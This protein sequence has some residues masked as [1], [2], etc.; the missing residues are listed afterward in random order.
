MTTERLEEL[1]RELALDE[2]GLGSKLSE[3]ATKDLLALIDKATPKAVITDGTAES[4]K[5]PMCPAC[6]H[7]NHYTAMFCKHCGRAIKER[8]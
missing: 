3:R 6:R 8:E 2:N 1:K 7:P 5:Y 4:I